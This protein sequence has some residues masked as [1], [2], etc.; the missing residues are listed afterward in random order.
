MWPNVS[1]QPSV[2]LRLKQTPVAV[3]LPDVSNDVAYDD[4]LRSR[5]G[6]HLDA[7]EVRTHT[8]RGLKRA[9]VC[10]IVLDRDADLHGG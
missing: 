2:P 1:P 4:E 7:H 3:R 9:A 8:D 6:R 5:L 10:I